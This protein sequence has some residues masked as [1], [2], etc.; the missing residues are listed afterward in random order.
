MAIALA[1]PELGLPTEP[2]LIDARLDAE[3]ALRVSLIEGTHNFLEFTIDSP[4]VEPQPNQTCFV[5]LGRYGDVMI[6]LPA[7]KHIFDTTGIKPVLMICREFAGILD[8]VSYVEPWPVDGLSWVMGVKTARDGADRYFKKVF[9]PKY[10]DCPGMTPDHVPDEKVSIQGV[11][12]DEWN[13]YMFSQW[14]SCGFTRRQIIDWPLVFDRRDSN[15]EK[16]LC[17]KTIHGEKPVVLYNFSGFSSPM[18]AEK[19][20]LSSL[21]RL[22]GKIQMVNLFD[23]TAKNIYDLLGLY[24][25]SLCLVTGDTATLHLAAAHKI[26]MVALVNN[27]GSGSIVKGNCILKVRYA[28]IQSRVQEIGKAVE[29]LL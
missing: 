8:G 5:Q 23:V 1:R 7:M 26:P 2:H 20:V 3:N 19:E 24:D 15:R 17:D 22:D 13:S 12:D 14:K 11:E 25:R 6:I 16:L 18:R 9:V 29:K 4:P 10:W 27:G 21:S 28:E